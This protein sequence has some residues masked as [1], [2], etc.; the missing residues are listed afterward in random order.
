MNSNYTVF[1]GYALSDNAVEGRSNAAHC[2]TCCKSG[3]S[4]CKRSCSS[5]DADHTHERFWG[6]AFG[7]V[8]CIAHQKSHTAQNGQQSLA[9]CP[10]ES[11]SRST[12]QSRLK[13]VRLRRPMLGCARA[14][15]AARCA[16]FETG[17]KLC[18]ICTPALP[19]VGPTCYFVAAVY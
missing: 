3:R 18:G 15:C 5:K 11:C 4:S 17:Q 10:R 16:H 1:R 8:A 13:P 7:C 14:L 9:V 19:S 6:A 2:S 12:T